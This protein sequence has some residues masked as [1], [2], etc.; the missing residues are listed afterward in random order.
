MALDDTT[1]QN[2]VHLYSTNTNAQLN[3]GYLVSQTGNKRGNFYGSGFALCTDDF[4][5][6]VTHKGLYLSTHGR[7]GPQGTQMDAT[8]ATSQLKAGAALTKNLSDTASRA[9]AE[10]LV[11]QEALNTFIDATQ[12]RYEGDG[13]GGANRFKEPV[14]LAGSPAGIGLASAQ[15]THVHAGAEVTLS[16]GQDTNIAVGK[17]LLASIAEKISLFAYNAGIKL[18]A[19]KGKVEVQA[20]SGDLDLI[21]EKVVR[22][23]STTARIEIHAKEEVLISA[24]GSFVKINGSGITNGTSGTWTAQASMHTMPGPVTNSHVM[25]H[26]PK[27][28]LEKND[29][30]FRHMTDWG[31]PLAGAAY[32]AILSDGSIRKGI[33]DAAGIARI[34]GVPPG[35]GAK[36]EY[37]YR[38]LQA[39]STVSTEL[40]D[41]VHELLNWVPGGTGKKGQA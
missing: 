24:G 4:G 5:A 17:S 20:Q 38:P 25:P 39:S 35:V 30:E 37:D 11:G 2:R 8:E 18:F 14:L 41:D 21:A 15:G 40:D 22:M 28:E 34:S 12:D 36:I 26:V 9:G 16:S 19:A 27:P 32:K 6:I 10:P 29:L 13:Q 1:G 7:P 31:E 3:L 23:L 33:L